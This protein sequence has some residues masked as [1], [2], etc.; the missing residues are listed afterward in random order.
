VIAFVVNLRR[1]TT[2][3]ART[4]YYVFPY[5]SLTVSEKPS[6]NLTAINLY[7]FF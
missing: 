3:R 2:G 7:R 6:P 5:F 4:L 1:G